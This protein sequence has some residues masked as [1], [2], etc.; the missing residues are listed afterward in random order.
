MRIEGL[1]R[2][3]HDRVQTVHFVGICGSGMCG[4]AEILKS[5]G[6]RVRGSDIGA[7]ATASRLKKLGIKIFAHH[8]A[9]NLTG[10][11]LLVFSSAIKEDNPELEAARHKGIPLVRRA[12]MLAEIMRF[13]FGIAV[14]G[15]HGKTTTTSMLAEVLAAC[16]EDV[17]FIVGGL[18]K[19]TD[20]NARLGEGK[21]VIAEADESDASFLHLHPDITIV[22]NID[23]EH[24]SGYGGSF[25][26]VKGGFLE[27]LHNLPFYG[28]AVLCLDNKEVASL[29][30]E[31]GRPYVTYGLSKDADYR[32]ENIRQNQE[33][34]DFDVVFPNGKKSQIRIHVPG[35]HNVLN[36]LACLATANELKLAK[37][38]MIKGLENFRGVSRR[39]DCLGVFG[40]QQVAN[41]MLIDDYGHHPCEIEATLNAIKKGWPNRR[42][43]MLF[44][45]HRYTR[46]SDLYDEFVRVLGQVDV[47]FLLDIYAAEEKPIA[48]VDS[49]Q[50]SMSLRR[51][52]EVDPIYV[53][54]IEELPELLRRFLRTDDIFITQGAGSI[55]AI[56]QR[57]AQNNMYLNG[58]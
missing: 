11:D 23:K 51:F 36:A 47:L 48:G 21:Y 20:S 25:S 45:P 10:A 41:I 26:K 28:L 49:H 13:S 27:F 31:V 2:E 19:S 30:G 52:G 43:I 54:D 40:N 18:V 32:A 34:T 33:V 15:S 29:L 50:L 57:L 44:Q 9:E 5:L 55:A 12:E 14:S 8:K 7:S 39:Q 58:L 35:E 3:S 56:A 38:D 42:C 6:Y 22:T 4:I 24:L 46:T 16:G 53:K 37:G 17:T 1:A